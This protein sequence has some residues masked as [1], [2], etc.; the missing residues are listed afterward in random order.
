MLR[1]LLSHILS[2][3]LRF[4]SFAIDLFVLSIFLL[5]YE[6]ISWYLLY[7]F[8]ISFSKFTFMTIV[9]LF[10]ISYSILLPLKIEGT[11][12]KKLCGIKIRKSNSERLT[13]VNIFRR[14]VIS[15]ALLSN[16][17]ALFIFIALLLFTGFI[18]VDVA[19]NLIVLSKSSVLYWEEGILLFY[20]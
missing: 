3:L 20:Q 6:K 8:D 14:E 2:L 12:G 10:Y 18:S 13:W 9:I 5:L 16:I 4:I 1:S 19:T 15:V 11:I 7:D 17:R